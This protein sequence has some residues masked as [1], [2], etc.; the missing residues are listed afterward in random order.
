MSFGWKSFGLNSHEVEKKFTHHRFKFL[1]KVLKDCVPKKDGMTSLTKRSLSWTLKAFPQGSHEMGMSGTLFGLVP[2]AAQAA[3]FCWCSYSHLSKRRWSFHGN[4]S[5]CATSGVG[6]LISTPLPL[7]IWCSGR[8][9]LVL[10]FP[11][12]TVLDEMTDRFDDR[13]LGMGEEGVEV[14]GNWNCP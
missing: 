7:R 2:S 6:P 3:S 9:V 11:E 1:W 10:E 4:R 13:S 12:F 14:D 5:C 8:G